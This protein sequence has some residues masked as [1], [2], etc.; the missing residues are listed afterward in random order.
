MYYS[1]NA[2]ATSTGCSSQKTKE[3]T[4]QALLAVYHAMQRCSSK[5]PKEQL[6]LLHRS[7]LSTGEPITLPLSAFDCMLQSTCIE[8]HGVV[9]LNPATKLSKVV[10]SSTLSGALLIKAWSMYILDQWVTIGSKRL[11]FT[12]LINPF[13]Y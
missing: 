5:Q 13:I 2:F 7:I 1:L 11:L 8:R 3:V 12:L 10:L 4:I 9:R 6:C